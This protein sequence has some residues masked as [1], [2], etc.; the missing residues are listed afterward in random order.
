[1][2]YQKPSLY[3]VKKLIL[4]KLKNLQNFVG[5]Y[6]DIDT[7]NRQ[8]YSLFIGTEVIKIIKTHIIHIDLGE[9]Y[10]KSSEFYEIQFANY[11]SLAEVISEPI[12]Q[13]EIAEVSQQIFELCEKKREELKVFEIERIVDFLNF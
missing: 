8:T 9:I 10:Q 1:M 13:N 4:Y 12:F 7:S 5:F 3:A 6:Y 11:I 2:M